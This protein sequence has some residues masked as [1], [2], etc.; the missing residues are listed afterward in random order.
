MKK[1][2]NCDRNEDDFVRNFLLWK[3]IKIIWKYQY[4]LAQVNIIMITWG[5]WT[6]DKMGTEICPFFNKKIRFGTLRLG[7]TGSMM[8]KFHRLGNG[9]SIHP[10]PPYSVHHPLTPPPPLPL[11]IT[12]FR[13]L[14]L[15]GP[16]V[17]VSFKHLSSLQFES[18][19]TCDWLR[20]NKHDTEQEVMAAVFSK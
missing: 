17:L 19:D 1:S 4:L 14:F 7:I 3:L 5:A 12:L 2:K 15:L 6:W 16:H 11:S 13:T 9:I 8:T 20:I 18:K 10:T